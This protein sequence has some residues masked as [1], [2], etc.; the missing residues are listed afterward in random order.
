MRVLTADGLRERLRRIDGRG[1][2]AYRDLEGAYRFAGFILYV[3]HAQG[4]PF[5]PP[6]RVR[7]RVRL[8]DAGFPSWSW[9]GRVAQVALCDFLARKLFH[10][11][12]TFSRR[13]GTGNGGQIFTA[14]PGQEILERSAVVLDRASDGPYLEARFAVGLPARGRTIDGGAAQELF[15]VQ[16]PQ[17]VARALGFH[18]DD[19]EALGRHVAVAEDQAALRVL[20]EERGWVAFVADGSILPRL[21]GASDAPMPKE[22]AVAFVSPPE[23]RVAVRLPHAGEITGMAVPR[24]VTLIVGGGY[25]GKSTLLRALELGVYD[26]VPGDGREYVVTLRDAVKIR[27]E[28]RRSVVGVDIHAFIGE[29]PGG[30]DTRCFTSASAS[31]STSQAANLVE[32][33]EAGARLILMDEDTSATNFLVRDARMQALVPKSS[34]PITPLVDRVRE[35]YRVLGM[36]TI[37]VV[38][39]VG[40]YLDVADTVIRMDRYRAFEATAEAREVVRRIPS[41]RNPEEAEPLVPPRPRVFH[42]ASFRREERERVRAEGL[43][44]IRFGRETIDLAAVEQLVDEGQTRAL[45]YILARMEKFADYLSVR[46]T[47]GARKDAEE[48]WMELRE[49]LAALEAL[50]EEKGVDGLFLPGETPTGDLV[51]PRPYEIAAAINRARVLRAR[52]KG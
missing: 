52:P 41:R 21:S 17:L 29:L 31:G 30:T 44:E 8:E 14:V 15:F 48:G 37:L 24:G 7:V 9:A 22:R 18:A 28:D 50:R 4:D 12:R 6:S 38:G 39:G 32:A 16:I 43:R 26:H 5:A 2:K 19:A 40:D 35:V 33:W 11:A 36:S 3:D 10:A 23:R 47:G 20:L 42:V 27:A 51:F 45:A 49:F 1:Y 13:T 25:H 34:E 46:K